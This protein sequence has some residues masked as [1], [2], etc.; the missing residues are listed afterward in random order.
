MWFSK[1]RRNWLKTQQQLIVEKKP[2]PEV[3]KSVFMKTL[4]LKLD[5]IGRDSNRPVLDVVLWAIERKIPIS[6]G[7]IGGGLKY[8]P[9][10]VVEAIKL[11]ANAGFV[12]IW[13]HGYGHIRYDQITSDKVLSDVTKGHNAV[14]DTFGLAPNGFGFPFNKYSDESVAIIR[15]AFPSYFIYETDLGAFNLTSPENNSFADGQPRLWY[16]KDCVRSWGKMPLGIVMQVHPPRWSALGYRE[17]IDSVSYLTDVEGYTCMSVRDTL[18]TLSGGVSDDSN[19][20][21]LVAIVSGINRLSEKWNDRADDYVK[22]LSNFKSYFLSR[23]VSDTQKNYH[24]LRE[25]LYP[26]R[27]GSIIDVGCG[28]GNWSLPFWLSGECESLVLNDVNATI[29]NALKNELEQKTNAGQLTIDERN[30]LSMPEEHGYTADLLVSANTFN[31]LDPIDFF[32]LVQSCVVPQG[33]LLLMVQGMAFNELRYRLALEAKDRSVGAEALSS[34]LGMILRRSFN[35]CTNGVRH[36]FSIDE[37]CKLAVMFDFT[38]ESHFLP[39]GEKL[40]DEGAVYECLLFKRTTGMSSAIQERPEW[41]RECQ[42]SMGKSFGSKA[43]TAAGLPSKMHTEYCSFNQNWTFTKT[44]TDL[45]RAAIN[46]IKSAIQAIQNGHEIPVISID[47]VLAEN[48]DLHKLAD[49]I[50]KFGNAIN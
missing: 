43:L 40:T 37:I 34:D 22:S 15:N 5:D 39:R 11:G 36:V 50:N 25:V 6:I 12:E 21:G 44:V 38:I 49:K 10:I 20:K 1:L 3:E 28:L 17:F 41:L 30:L 14:V 32:R 8:L 24:Q 23:F 18:L 16:Y 42:D 2:C 33:R 13:N 9:G 35:I 29:V 48:T 46:D 45:H 47:S 4:I 26:F 31:Y 19:G 27:P 7:T